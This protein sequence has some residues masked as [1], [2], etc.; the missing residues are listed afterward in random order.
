MSRVIHTP[1]SSIWSGEW[2]FS[3]R[4]AGLFLATAA[5]ILTMA[6]GGGSGGGGGN[7]NPNAAPLITTQPAGQTVKAGSPT[8]FTVAATGTPA[9]SFTWQRSN[10]SGTTWTAIS[11]ATAAAYTFTAA[12]VDNAAQFRATA[13]NA[14][15]PDATS[16][17][18]TLSV[19]WLAITT[20]PAS[21]SV[22]AG[23]PATFTVVPDAN[24][25]AT[26]QWQSSPDGTTWTDLAGAT[27]ASYTT[28][29]TSLSNSDTQYRCVLSN[30]TGSINSNAATLTV[31]ALVVAPAITTQPANASVTA[32]SPASFSVVATGTEPLHYQWKKGTTNVGTD[33]ATY[34]IAT[35][36]TGD[37]GS[38]T[39]TVSNSA[40]SV[41]SNAATLTVN[42]VPVITSL[43][44]TK[45]T[46]TTGTGTTLTA[47]F[48]GGT[49]S[50]NNGI[51]AVTTGVAAPTGNLTADATYTLTVTNASGTSVTQQVTVSVVAAPAITSFTATKSPITTGT[52][53]TLT[54]VF[55]GGT[56]AVDQG[57]GTVT[58]GVAAATGNLTADTTYTLTVTNA[59][60][61]SVT[62]QVTVTVVAAPAITSFTAAKSPITTGTS[63]TLT[64]VFTGGAGSV[65]HGVGAV[66]TAVGASTG[67]LTADTTYT[68]TVTNAA[69]TSVTHQ[70]TVSVVAAP[71]ITSFTAAKS[72]ITTG[73]S[74]TLTGVFTGGTGSVDQS[75]GAVTT[76]IAAATGNLTADTTYILTVTNAVGTSVT[77]TVTVNVVA[78]PTITSFTAANSPITTGTSTTLTGVFTG[79]TGSVDNS[80][81]T[82]TTAIAV[83]TGNLTATTTYTLTVT[84]TAG[85]SVTQ[86]VTVTVV[87][88]PVIGSFSATKNPIT[89][90][91]STTLTGVFTGGTGSVDNGVGSVT[92]AVGASTGNLTTTTTYTLTV[93][94]P[95][96]ASVMGQVTVAVIA[97]PT[98]TSFVNDGPIASGSTGN[99]TATFTVDL[100]GTA[101]VDRAIGT[102]ITA[103]PKSTGI[104]TATT[105]FT[106]TVTNEAGTSVTATTTVSVPVPVFTHNPAPQLLVPGTTVT[107]DVGGVSSGTVTWQRSDDSGLTWSTPFAGTTST[108]YAY[109][110]SA[111]PATAL[112][113]NG[114][115]FRAVATNGYGSTASMAAG[116]N[117]KLSLTIP[118]TGSGTASLELMLIPAAGVGTFTMGETD[119]P[120]IVSE[121]AA[122][123]AHPVTIAK[124]FYIAKVPCTQAQW[125][126]I[127]GGVNPSTFTGDA[128]KLPVESVS[129]DDITAAT[130]GF[131]DK[132]NAAATGKPASSF[133]RLP[134][135]AEY[136]YACRAGSRGNDNYYFGSYDPS[137][138]ADAAIIDT[139]M[140]SLSNSTS[141]S[142]PSGSTQPVGVKLPNAWGLFDMIGNVWEV[143][144]D[145]WHAN[146]SVTGAGI[147]PRPD[148]GTA[149]VDS[150]RATLRAF[151]GGSCQH[152]AHYGQSKARGS[153]DHTLRSLT[154]GFRVV[155][156][157][158]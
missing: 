3:R 130:T 5:L 107:F 140:W 90:G 25:A 61:T 60:G 78:A 12:K 132:L 68:L 66:T 114:A 79:G 17:A 116:L 87:A 14:V 106:L 27:S 57:I 72:P 142:F 141:L 127:M 74:T 145:D 59:A 96:G 137:S 35:T 76:G 105:T 119:S 6:C 73:T 99:L 84:N 125:L 54:G 69:G 63:T 122:L 13:T 81:G 42:A 67:N 49:G 32:G 97:A 143:C 92:T 155:L 109:T 95:A 88:A 62:Q 47:V 29:A 15:S 86:P 50:V 9:P 126:A 123:P 70:V 82:V 26:L 33:S 148:D 139:Y 51:G 108:T 128:T 7:T 58:T 89:T 157:L 1:P 41:T 65:D 21:A 150:P 134:T 30:A 110:P 20:Q 77:Q 156:Q 38:Y 93:T 113:D 147:S 53:T 102:V 158:P 85:T 104:L 31:T 44:A 91:T 129:F 120:V 94:N 144:Q 19:Q 16:S 75:L 43:V 23:N 135:E 136:E 34:S 37:A 56:G 55:A 121:A 80:V 118:D 39:V 71:V 131:L 138:P 22:T 10:D 2:S 40:S 152:G 100:A 124:A 45:S 48:T 112:L 52:S 98:I 117:E 153:D 11:G 18:A 36:A 103:T 24:P 115:L 46:V 154:E 151:R 28:D 101:L 149:W 8:T 83:N 64:G 146:Y 4:F 133:F 111:T